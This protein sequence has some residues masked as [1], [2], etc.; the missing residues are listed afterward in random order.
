MPLRSEWDL[1][2]LEK[3]RQLPHQP[4]LLHA[5]A[6][7][8]DC[9]AQELLHALY[10]RCTESSHGLVYSETIKWL[11]ER[12]LHRWYY[13]RRRLIKNKPRVLV[14]PNIE[15]QKV[16]DGIYQRL[17]VVPVSLQSTASK[18]W[19]SAENHAE[20]HRWNKYLI[21]E[22]IKDAY[23]SIDARRVLEN[24]R[25]AVLKD[26]SL[27]FPALSQSYQEEL[28]RC[29]VFLTVYE[30][31]LPQGVAT[32][33]R[34]I[35]IVFAK[36]DKRILKYLQEQPYYLNAR[37]SRYKDDIAVSYAANHTLLPLMK[38]LDTYQRQ[39]D[40]LFT[41]RHGLEQF[42]W[43]VEKL[44]TSGLR[45]HV[46][47]KRKKMLSGQ[48]P[49]DVQLQKKDYQLQ[50]KQLIWDI[51]Q[52]AY[53][54][55][56][57][58]DHPS[59]QDI[60]QRYLHFV[61]EDIMLETT[62]IDDQKMRI[63]MDIRTLLHEIITSNL[64]L[65]TVLE[66][67]KYHAFMRWIREKLLLIQDKHEFVREGNEP[68]RDEFYQTISRL[69]GEIDNLAVKHYIKPSWRTIEAL[70][71]DIVKILEQEWRHINPKKTKMW[72]PH[73]TTPREITWVAFE[74]DGRRILPPR[75]HKEYIR[76]FAL[77][78]R[79]P[80]LEQDRLQKS[81]T[82]REF[83]IGGRVDV[84]HI[85]SKIQGIRNRILHVYGEKSVPRDLVWW[86]KQVI[87]RREERWG[88]FYSLESESWL[89]PEPN[90]DV[91]TSTQDIDTPEN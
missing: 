70:Q 90:D 74:A 62:D 91:H 8:C 13:K 49:W 89:L 28:I 72:T 55:E 47:S 50:R 73:A 33:D 12:K 14:T 37:Y 11:K 87:Q 31:Q 32:S 64:T 68:Y 42:E 29:I 86:H 40:H 26:L 21:T 71:Q 67:Q 19:D 83:I 41:F 16:Q 46:S 54:L 3:V 24:L 38:L 76:I 44:S 10:S 35:N 23:P 9:T 80:I 45:G 75:K 39:F 56:H 7:F 84:T 79:A 66:S 22:D 81:H 30:N 63:L 65:S 61:H 51:T 58:A 1:F 52:G 59:Y 48:I 20:F 82:Y 15:L 78:C 2:W 18:K 4:Q 36:I 17:G 34:I 25:W 43:I 57:L 5:L 69:I 27:W 60:K 53:S 77:L 88:M 6:Q 85:K